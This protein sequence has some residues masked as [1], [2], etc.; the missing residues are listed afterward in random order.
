MSGELNETRDTWEHLGATDPYWAVLTEDD[1]HEGSARAKF[2]ESGRAE[3]SSVLAFLDRHERPYGKVAVDFG[4]GVGRL[5]IALADHFEQVYGVDVAQSMLEEARVNNPHGERVQFIHNAADTL[6]FDDNSVDLVVSLITLQHIPPALSLRYLLE[7]IRIVRPGGHLLFQVPSHLP[8]PTPI[9]ESHCR[10]EITILDLPA[11]IAPGGSANVR[12]S[13]RNAGDGTWPVNQLLNAGNHWHH[14]GEVHRYDDGRIAIPPLSPGQS[15]EV[16][17]RVGIP[18]QPGTYELEIDLVQESVAWW[19]Q[20]SSKTTRQTVVVE[21]TAPAAVEELAE[22]V[23]EAPGP[24]LNMQM[25]G[26]HVDLLRALFE[27]L[28]CT[29]L[30][31]AP[32]NRT[33][34]SWVSNFY[35]VEIGEYAVRMRS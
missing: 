15:A 25:H 31:I 32:D 26:L 6:P 9:P 27:Q 20:L 33:G 21:S 22:V 10:A 5:T 2:F 24:N 35:V 18:E 12:L 7:M 17:L 14:H 16:V 34:A 19:T 30:E 11:K 13:V 8:A 1:Y 4:C 28:C 29:V 3:I 23:D